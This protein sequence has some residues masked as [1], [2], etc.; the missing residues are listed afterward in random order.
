M[1]VPA[2]MSPMERWL[3][4][5]KARSSGFFWNLGRLAGGVVKISTGWTHH[6]THDAARYREFMGPWWKQ[7]IDAEVE[8]FRKTILL[9]RSYRAEVKVILLPQGSWMDELPFKSYYESKIRSLCDMSSIPLID[10]SRAIPDE[11]FADSNHLTVR[12]QEEFRKL[13]ME[14]IKKNLQ[15]IKPG[16]EFMS[17]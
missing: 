14:E 4:I 17:H 11:D 9:V 15:Q 13:I 6:P 3:R 5:E 12:G 7:N 1:I 16:K 8:Q 10:L 2:D